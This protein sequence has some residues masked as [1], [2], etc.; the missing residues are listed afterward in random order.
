MFCCFWEIQPARAPHHQ[1]PDFRIFSGFSCLFRFLVKEEGGAD[2]GVIFKLT[3]EGH[4][5]KKTVETVAK[6]WRSLAKKSRADLFATLSKLSDE[7]MAQLLEEL[8]VEWI[9]HADAIEAAERKEKLVEQKKERQERKEQR[10]L[11]KEAADE[12]AKRKQEEAILDAKKQSNESN[13]R[14]V[15]FYARI[16]QS[17]VEARDHGV[18]QKQMLGSESGSLSDAFH[19][20]QRGDDDQELVAVKQYIGQALLARKGLNSFSLVQVSLIG[21]RF[22]EVFQYHQENKD[23]DRFDRKNWTNYDAYL[24][25]IAPGVSIRQERNYRRTYELSKIFPCILLVSDCSVNEFWLHLRKFRDLLEQDDSEA[26]QWRCPKPSGVGA[27]IMPFNRKL[28]FGLAERG[29]ARKFGEHTIS[30]QPQNEEEFV[31]AKDSFLNSWRQEAT[32]PF[33][34]KQRAY[35]GSE[36]RDDPM[37]LDDDEDE[38]YVDIEH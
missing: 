36:E 20:L 34:K 23:S 13:L 15:L 38:E 24:S 12:E 3:M 18:L 2:N 14:F 9:E 17:M 5:N 22:H 25:I 6:I 10:K 31:A 11:E 4:A 26:L 35:F 16:K 21:K 30:G 33:R 7:V 32:E 19:Q 28:E 29:S 27:N 8:P 1:K 37:D